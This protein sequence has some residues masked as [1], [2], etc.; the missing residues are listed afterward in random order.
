MTDTPTPLSRDWLASRL[1]DL[2]ACDTT[3][4]VEDLGLPALRALLMELGAEVTEQAVAPGRTNVLATWGIP[5]ILFS[6][7]L[8][9]VPPFIA[10]R[11]EGD[12]VHGR[13]AC[14]AKGQILAQLAAI[15]ALR[16]EGVEGL[17]WLGVVGEETDSAGA[18]AALSL[19]MPALR[20][21][22]NGE[23]T[24][25]RLA[26]GQRGA[27]HLHLECRGVAAHSGSP[28]L[29][30]SAIWEL[31]DWL[32]RL[33]E[34]PRPADPALGPEV[35]NLGRIGGGD[36]V[37]VVPAHAEAELLART[38]P[39]SDFADRVA[40]L[41]PERGEIALRLSEPPDLYPAVDGFPMAP[42]PFGSDA[43]ALRALVPDRT[44]VLAG[45]GRIEVAHRP[46]EHLDL[47]DLEAGIALN[48]RLARHF[49]GSHL[50]GS[51]GGEG[52]K[53]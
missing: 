24:G 52:S 13:G 4:G 25:N 22:I 37:N 11:R 3:S 2:C 1:M 10:P 34:E 5:E 42:M 48:A 40:A 15:R 46:D 44:V 8:D 38:L 14:D 23:P 21:L 53:R 33:R 51:K 36:A 31:T 17:A 6:T 9:T 20:A 32:Q 50:H 27:L 43:P 16:E 26:T 35:W 29:G 30:R 19:S 47:E 41:R 18:R 45:P 39:G 28:E 49:L 7:H 12:R